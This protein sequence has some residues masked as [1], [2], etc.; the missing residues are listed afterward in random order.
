ME[1][2]VHAAF[3][4]E[5]KL[6]FLVLRVILDSVD[7]VIPPMKGV[8]TAEGKN[9]PLQ[10]RGPYRDP[11]ATSAV[12]CTTPTMA[13]SNAAETISRLCPDLLPQAGRAGPV[14]LKAIVRALIAS[15]LNFFPLTISFA[16]H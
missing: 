11:S 5:R 6:P 13:G 7:M 1:S 16:V 2:G 14:E 8:T 9:P 15:A 10:S 4:T 12:F 3:A